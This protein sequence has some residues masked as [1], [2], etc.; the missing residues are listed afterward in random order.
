M[1]IICMNRIGDDMKS[2]SA[3]CGH[4]KRNLNQGK[5]LEGRVLEFALS[6][7]EGSADELSIEI[8]RKLKE[9]ERLNNYEHHIMVDVILLH[10][11][12][13]CA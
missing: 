1:V 10:V 9:G 7:V 8:G 5:P 12:L 4:V 2:I 13:G 3:K 11:K 6:L